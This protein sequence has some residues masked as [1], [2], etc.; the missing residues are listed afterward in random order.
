M[1]RAASLKYII[2]PRGGGHSSIIICQY[3]TFFKERV[4]RGN[5]HTCFTS[6]GGGGESKA[7]HLIHKSLSQQPSHHIELLS[8]LLK[9]K[10][11]L[12]I[13]YIALNTLVELRESPLPRRR[14][15]GGG[16]LSSSSPHVNSISRVLSMNLKRSYGMT[17]LGLNKSSWS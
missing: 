10:L 6:T 11:S 17:L 7:A 15:G 4:E 13:V 16:V 14:Q 3:M 5:I 2:R 8:L 9:L 1:S 12:H